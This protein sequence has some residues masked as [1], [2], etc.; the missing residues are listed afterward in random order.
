MSDEVYEVC[1]VCA[2]NG[3]TTIVQ[4][5]GELLLIVFVPNMEKTNDKRRT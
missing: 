2:G 4:E 5:D 1:E 3:W